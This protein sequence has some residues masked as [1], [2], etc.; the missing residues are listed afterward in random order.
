MRCLCLII[1][2]SM[3]FACDHRVTI[4]PPQEA[5]V[6]PPMWPDLADVPAISGRPATKE[7][8]AAG[9]AVFVMQTNGDPLGQPIDIQLPQYAY[10]IDQDTGQRTPGVLIQAEEASA[11]QLAGFVAL[12]DRSIMA[13]FLYEFELLGTEKPE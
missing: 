6:N 9:R 11:Q 2:F 8:V 10:H 7:G 3:V 13:A 5:I 1:L 4:S 12:P